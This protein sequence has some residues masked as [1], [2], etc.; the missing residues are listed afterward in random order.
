[1][2]RKNLGWRYARTNW[3][4]PAVAATALVA[5]AGTR[6]ALALTVVPTF[7]QSITSLS[8][9]AAIEAAIQQAD[10]TYSIFTNPETVTILYQA[11]FAGAGLGVYNGESVGGD[12]A[13]P[14]ATYTGA[15]ATNATSN[16]DPIEQSVVA[17]LGSG[18][19][20]QQVFASTADLRALGFS[21]YTGYVSS[22]NPATNQGVFN[23]PQTYDGAMMLNLSQ[24][25]S[26]ALNNNPI[27]S[28]QVDGLAV[29][30]HETD[31]ILG[32]G[33]NGSTLNLSFKQGNTPWQFNGGTAIGPMD[34][35]RYGA[36]GVPS[37]TTASFATPAPYFSIT[38][39]QTTVNGA[40]GPVY[41]YQNNNGDYGDWASGTGNV[42]DANYFPSNQVS[43][44]NAASPEA[45][46]LQAIGYNLPACI[47]ECT[48]PSTRPR[49]GWAQSPSASC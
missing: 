41:F 32:I 3:L 14:Y 17:N 37:L 16:Q 18:N 10:S 1:M 28:N 13:I 36:P 19:T 31:E 8:N 42:Q 21:K 47:G 26:F 5:G 43:S 12:A 27:P 39:G 22:I 33:G 15:L 44:I 2:P 11:T 40:I 9:A 25:M 49:Q 38:G 24:N 48:I 30:E 7:S 34:L 29:I 6:S 23:G 4:A 20:A 45:V 46:A 35:F